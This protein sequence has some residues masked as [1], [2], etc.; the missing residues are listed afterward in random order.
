MPT[1]WEEALA[2]KEREDNA[3]AEQVLA[4]GPTAG[5]FLEDFNGQ[6]S[7]F[8]DLSEGNASQLDA[9]QAS[10]TPSEPIPDP[11]LPDDGPVQDATVSQ[12]LAQS[13]PGYRNQVAQDI[14]A[15]AFAPQGPSDLDKLA[16]RSRGTAWRHGRDT[17]TNRGLMDDAQA[18]RAEAAN[19]LGDLSVSKAADAARMERDQIAKEQA[20]F[21]VRQEAKELEQ[22]QVAT[23]EK[24]LKKEVDA[25]KK[26][27]IDPDKFFKDEDGNEN[28]GKR[29]MASIAMAMGA[30]G[31]GMTGGPNHAAKIITDQINNDIS[32][33][34]ANLQTMKEGIGEKRTNFARLR[35]KFKDNDLAYL[36]D[37]SQRI[38]AHQQ[39]LGAL[40]TEY[41]GAEKSMQIQDTNAQLEI[42][43]VKNNQ[44]FLDRSTQLTQAGHSFEGGLVMAQA[45]ADAQ[46]KGPAPSF[47]GKS[48]IMTDPAAAQAAMASLDKTEK[49]GLREGVAALAEVKA[50][51]QEYLDLRKDK[52]Y[53]L[54]P[55]E[56]SEK[57]RSIQ[58]RLID[59]M[60]TIGKMGVP[61]EYELERLEEEVPGAGT[62]FD[63][64]AENKLNG[65][66]SSLESG[67]GARLGELGMSLQG[68][69]GAVPGVRRRR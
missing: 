46:K 68:T 61:Q 48:V 49:K 5:G 39:A 6:D 50:L 8:S 31:S 40:D 60:R 36:A 12:A 30:F 38:E 24:E 62:F 3:L 64:V 4:S 26:E 1:A 45:R 16:K 25:F 17:R 37:K 57:Q 44:A 58:R 19:L 53:E 52:S 41:A 66:V 20:A 7:S 55:T 13:A 34:R 67:V 65:L 42:E 18:K 22:K 69:S 51:R 56:S 54:F 28:Y 23:Y 59:S 10:R 63:T 9:W 35:E 43:K 33:Q 11:S 14:Q 15:G 2:E 32:A 29:I 21:G 27:K 47:L